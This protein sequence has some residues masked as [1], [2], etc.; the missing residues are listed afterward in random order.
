MVCNNLNNTNKGT[1][2]INKTIAEEID[3][4]VEIEI[5]K[6]ICLQIYLMEIGIVKN[7]I[8]GILKVDLTVID[9]EKIKLMYVEKFIIP[10]FMVIT[11]EIAEGAIIEVEI[12]IKEVDMVVEGKVI[13]VS[14]VVEVET[15]GVIGEVEVETVEV[16]VKEVEEVVEEV[17][18]PLL[19]MVI[20]NV[21]YV[22]I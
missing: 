17:E 2:V 7:V 16:S 21:P 18:E 9:V 19:V 10:E 4:E 15:E 1:K 6:K 8:I 12:E 5:L 11:K 14:T 3:Q 20:G 13:E 22:R